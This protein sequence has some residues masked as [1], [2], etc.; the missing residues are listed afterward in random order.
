MIKTTPLFIV[1]ASSEHIHQFNLALERMN[2][3]VQLVRAYAVH[4]EAVL[5]ESIKELCYGCMVDH[6]SQTQHDVCLMMSEE[7]R[8]YHCL[9]KCLEYVSEEDIMKTFTTSL[10]ICEILRCPPH[11]YSKRFRQ[12]LWFRG[13]W[14]DDVCKEIVRIKESRD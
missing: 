6:P 7:E 3:Y 12:H 1:V 10:D 8:L 4:I 13:D 14:I 2:L 9:E 11:F 5:N